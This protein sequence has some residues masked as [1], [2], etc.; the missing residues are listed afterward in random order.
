VVSF[1]VFLLSQ[2]ILAGFSLRFF[3]LPSLV[4]E[5][6][7]LLLG[8]RATPQP[9]SY[10]E[11]HVVFSF[12][13]N[14]AA[15]PT[16]FRFV[17]P[18]VF[19]LRGDQPILRFFDLNFFTWIPPPSWRSSR[20][21]SAF[22]ARTFLPAPTPPYITLIVSLVGPLPPTPLPFHD[23][24]EDSSRTV[25]LGFSSFFGLPGRRSPCPSSRVRLYT[26]QST[27]NCSS[28]SV[29]AS[30]KRPHR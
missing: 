11:R 21:S 26:C 27:T 8:V 17:F 13:V 5:A 16:P 22:F 1:Y 19:F 18:S 2:L 6:I 15:P 14:D 9:P 10:R 20:S 29:R 3:S 7:C 28:L 4:L 23:K 25:F 30:A 12:L 24:N